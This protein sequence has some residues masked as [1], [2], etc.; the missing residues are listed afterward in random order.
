MKHVFFAIALLFLATAVFAAE[1]PKP[2]TGASGEYTK[3]V[4][5]DEFDYEGLPNPEK[6]GY[7][8]GYVR[9][10]EKQYYTKAR[11]ENA[12]VKDGQLII[13]V[14]QDEFKIADKTAPITSASVISKGKGTWSRGRIEVKAKVPSSLGTWPAIWM[15]PQDRSMGWPQGGEIDIMEHVGFAP[16]NVHF[17]IHVKK[18][19]PGKDKKIEG[20][21]VPFGKTVPIGD[22][23]AFHIYAVE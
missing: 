6:W 9:N 20:K 11:I 5:S 8:T 22:A 14:R 19:H 3:L 10:N 16:E 1:P 18:N 23:A 13:T 21:T 7:E 12:E 4:W 2:S 15:L 17:N